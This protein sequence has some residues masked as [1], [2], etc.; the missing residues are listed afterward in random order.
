VGAGAKTIAR[1]D[2]SDVSDNTDFTG[3][4]SEDDTF[5]MSEPAISQQLIKLSEHHGC[6]VRDDRWGG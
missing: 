2:R 4:S 3:R 6:I 1:E 5:S